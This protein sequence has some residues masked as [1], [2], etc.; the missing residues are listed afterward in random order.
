MELKCITC[1]TV[2]LGFTI[3]DIG[4]AFLEKRYKC[5]KCQLSYSAEDMLKDNYGT[6]DKNQLH[7]IDFKERTPLGP[8]PRF[9]HD[10]R[11]I[12]HLLKTFREFAEKKQPVQVEWVDELT[13]LLYKE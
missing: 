5:K 11:R 10:G 4:P 1:H 13:E 7:N 9:V 6:A 12:K 8:I 3:H 2:L